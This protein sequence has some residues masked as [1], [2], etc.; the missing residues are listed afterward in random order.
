MGGLTLANNIGIPIVESFNTLA[1]NINTTIGTYLLT[2]E[3]MASSRLKAQ[4][5]D[6]ESKFIN[7]QI[8]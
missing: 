8:V 3:C 2:D 6:L 7:T 5:L 1:R 4:S